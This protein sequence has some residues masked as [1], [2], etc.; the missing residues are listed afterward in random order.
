MKLSPARLIIL[1]HCAAGGLAYAAPGQ[2][3]KK[4]GSG[5]SG[6]R[7]LMLKAMYEEGLI[8]RAGEITIKGTEALERHL[9]NG[10]SLAGTGKR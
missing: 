2:R 7:R 5:I 4:T 8:T 10:P 6:A 1:Q 9:H 3:Q